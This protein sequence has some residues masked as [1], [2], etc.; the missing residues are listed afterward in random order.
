MINRKNSTEIDIIIPI[1]NDGD[2]PDNQQTIDDIRE[3][4]DKCG[5]KRFAL[6]SPSPGWRA[7]GVPPAEFYRE[8][9][10]AFKKIKEALEPEGIECGWWITLTIKSGADPRWNRMIR[11]DGTE[12][13]MASCPLNPVFQKT[14][15]EYAALFIKIAKPAFVI[16]VL[17]VISSPST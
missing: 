15:A 8:R 2:W 13:P 16:T 5:F 14:F 6:T 1:S 9:A 17:N 10:E 12:T 4:H 11:M 7:T 3:Q